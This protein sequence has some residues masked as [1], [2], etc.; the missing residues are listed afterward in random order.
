MP[1]AQNRSEIAFDFV[2]FKNQSSI[3]IQPADDLG[4][5]TNIF[6]YTQSSYIVEQQAEFFRFFPQ[7][8]IAKQGFDGLDLVDIQPQICYVSLPDISR[9]LVDSIDHPQQ[10]RLCFTVNSNFGKFAVHQTTVINQNLDHVALQVHQFQEIC[11]YCQQLC[12]CLD[13]IASNQ[14]DIPLIK[15]TCAS[16][17]RSFITPERSECPPS[18]GQNQLALPACH[19]ACQGWRELRSKRYRVSSPIFKDKGLFLDQLLTGF[20]CIKVNGFQAGTLITLITI[21]LG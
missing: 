3:I 14:V 8:G 12:I 2:G 5:I 6:F 17:L 7:L 11:S 4:L 1:A 10:F 16:F 20:C 9:L 21:R 13:S 18:R 19:H 15:L